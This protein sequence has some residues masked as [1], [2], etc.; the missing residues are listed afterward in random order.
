ML[1]VGFHWVRA[2]WSCKLLV[3]CSQY[4][5]RI[6]RT[7]KARPDAA[8]VATLINSFRIG[9]AG[10]KRLA[11]VISGEWRPCV[12]SLIKYVRNY[13]FQTFTDLRKCNMSSHSSIFSCCCCFH[14][15]TSGNKASP[16][17]SR[18]RGTS[19]CIRQTFARPR[20]QRGVPS[21]ATRSV[22]FSYV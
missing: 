21:A 16:R 4:G 2:C 17:C 8:C 7:W 13:K 19:F 1:Y 14:E 3:L 22:V 20:Q 12:P 18:V 11:E 5:V 6:H 15:R 9:F 10:W